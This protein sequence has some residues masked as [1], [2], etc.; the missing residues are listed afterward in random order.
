MEATTVQA[1]FQELVASCYIEHRQDVIFAF[2]CLS[3]VACL[4]SQKSMRSQLE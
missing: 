2:T 3:N 1:P 4:S